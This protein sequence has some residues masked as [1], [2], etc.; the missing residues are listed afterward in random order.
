MR[1]PGLLRPL[2][3]AELS[4]GTL[5]YLLLCAALLPARPGP[6]IVLNEPEASLHPDLLQ[7]LGGL[8][9]AASQESQVV[10]VTHADRLAR[11]LQDAGALTHRLQPT[12]SGTRVEGQHTLERPPWHWPTR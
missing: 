3:T 8:V 7:P 11:A 2:E 4:D 5:R 12:P 6:L 9:E 1:Q 10:V